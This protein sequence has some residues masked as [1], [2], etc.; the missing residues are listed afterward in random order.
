M[1]LTPL[2][3][4]ATRVASAAGKMTL[5]IHQNTSSGAGFRGSLEGWSRAGIKHVVITAALLDEFLKT[6]TVPAARRV[7]TDLGLT[8]VCAASGVQGLWEP[9][10][11]HAASLEDLKRRCEM[12][13]ALGLNRIYSPTTTTQ[14][15]TEDDYKTAVDNMRHV[16]DVAKQFSLTFMAEFVRTSSFISTLPTLLKMT[17]AASH[18]NVAVLFDFYHFWSGL[19]KLEDLDVL[20]PG[21]IGH[22]HFQDVPDIPRELLDSTTRFIPGDGIAPLNA[23]LRKL[24]DKGYAG[25]LSVE[26]FLPKFQKGDPFE[27]AREIRQKAEPVMRQAR[28]L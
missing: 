16:G 22:V 4:L 3:L 9:N 1:L 28:V 12:F 15:F 8:P 26:L 13:A 18:P 24:S 11:N 25:P 19:N 14:K 10:P 27:V 17:R 6:D 5:A 20:R 23:I 2:A 21:E 7:L